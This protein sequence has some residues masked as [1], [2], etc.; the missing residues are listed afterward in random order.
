MTS[1]LSFTI[2][3]IVA[4]FG[5]E[6]IGDGALLINRV[7]PLV[8]AGVGDFS[9]S[10]GDKYKQ[11]L[12]STRATAVAVKP[13]DK[14]NTQAVRIISDNPYAYFAKVAA[15]LNPPRSTEPG[16]HASAVIDKTAQIAPSAQIGA[17]C[18]VGKHSI[19]GNN[20]VIGAGSHIEDNVSIADDSFLYPNVTIY[21]DCVIGKRVILHSGVV[22]GSD[23]FGFANDAGKW[24]K[25]PQLGR[26]IIGDDVEI[27]ANTTMD[28]GALD[29]TVIEEGVKLDNQIQ[30]AHNVRIGAH[31]AIAGCVGIAGSAKIG[32]HCT[33]GGASVVLGHLEIAD[34]VCISAGTLVTKSITQ[35][36]TYTSALPAIA[37]EEWR[38]NIVHLRHLNDWSA[39]IKH[40]ERLFTRTKGNGGE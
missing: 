21:H 36:G 35:P 27:G 4:R 6:L 28:R 3:E 2:Q 11:Q 15:L 30:V 23:G 14:D 22:I 1:Q 12:L 37:H 25:F 39:K 38:K 34:N 20:V 16:I 10:V 24:I 29:D 9:Y 19:V 40:L 8:R 5:G 26:A 13:Q 33:I 32:R 17:L 31:T 18:S 7:A